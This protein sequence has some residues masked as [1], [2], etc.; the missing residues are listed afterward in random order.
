MGKMSLMGILYSWK[1]LD[2]TCRVVTR[3]LKQ[4]QDISGYLCSGILMTC[5]NAEANVLEL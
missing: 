5:Q 1:E 2:M 4:N 3:D